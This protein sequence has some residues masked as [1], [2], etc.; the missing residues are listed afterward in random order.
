MNADR[1]RTSA[2]ETEVERRVELAAP[3]D[4]V[5]AALTNRARLSTWVGGSVEELDLR[6]GGRGLV[7]RSDG[8]VRR[9]VVDAVE[10]ERRLAL[11]WWPFED[12]FPQAG[13]GTRVEFDLEPSG[14][15][16]R[17]RVVEFPPLGLRTGGISG[18]APPAAFG[19][20]SQLP[21]LPTS[22]LQAATR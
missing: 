6:P 16:T 9:L 5:W 3:V 22:N 1:V 18:E 19:R 15:G 21:A 17:L 11:R 12:G 2:G 20:A 10:P 14:S 13:R 8:A 4:E 7:R